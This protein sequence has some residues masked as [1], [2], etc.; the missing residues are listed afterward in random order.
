MRKSERIEVR[1]SAEDKQL[2]TAAATKE[3]ATTAEFVREAV[4]ER[5]RRIEARADRTLMPAEQ[6][7][8]L[9]AALD[10]ADETPTMARAFARKR[11]FV[12]R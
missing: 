3:H 5:V 4:L 11:P 6:F 1:L 9:V 12:Q 8:A 7:D 2:I 10:R